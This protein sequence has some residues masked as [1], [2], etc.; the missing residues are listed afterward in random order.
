MDGDMFHRGLS[1]ALGQALASL[2]L[3]PDPHPWEQRSRVG[4]WPCSQCETEE[5]LPLNAVNK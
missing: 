5:Q 3:T 1:P 2:S 4:P